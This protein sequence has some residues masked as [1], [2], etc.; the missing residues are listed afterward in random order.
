MDDEPKGDQDDWNEAKEPQ[1]FGKMEELADLAAA[2][3]ISMVIAGVV[4]T[5]GI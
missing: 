1:G 2:V 4:Y 3:L 5:F